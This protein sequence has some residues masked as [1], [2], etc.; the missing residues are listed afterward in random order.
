MA[1]ARG[2]GVATCDPKMSVVVA[3]NGNARLAS[4]TLPRYSP[5]P[6]VVVCAQGRRDRGAWS[7]ISV[8]KLSMRE[9]NGTQ[10]ARMGRG[11]GCL[12]KPLKHRG[13]GIGSDGSCARTSLALATTPVVHSDLRNTSSRGNSAMRH[14][15][16]RNAGAKS[17]ASSIAFAFEVQVIVQQVQIMPLSGTAR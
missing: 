4:R 16:T 11:P 2:G 5:H 7:I 14:A 10:Q 15:S 13:V 1:R 8:D 12:T 3:R 6:V 9:A 17:S